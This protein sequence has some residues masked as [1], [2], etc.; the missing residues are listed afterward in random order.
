MNQ[1]GTRM[2]LACSHTGKFGRGHSPAVVVR[3]I[4]QIKVPAAH[5]IERML[6]WL[7][8]SRRIVIRSD[9]LAISYAAMVSLACAIGVYDSIFVQSQ[10]RLHGATGAWVWLAEARLLARR[11]TA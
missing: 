2:T 11:L 1:Y 7:K 6:E 3:E 8:E 9:K 10:R 4:R 5:I